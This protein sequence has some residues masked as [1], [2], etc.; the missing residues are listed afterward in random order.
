MDGERTGQ[1]EGLCVTR[2]QGGSSSGKDRQ[3]LEP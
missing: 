3:A 2:E 1:A